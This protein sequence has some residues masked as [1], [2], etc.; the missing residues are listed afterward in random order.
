MQA[1]TTAKKRFIVGMVAGNTA[2]DECY[3]LEDA[4][5]LNLLQ[6]YIAKLPMLESVV[7]L[8]DYVNENY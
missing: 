6:N 8:T 2:I 5:F 1:Q 4:V 3:L 7:R